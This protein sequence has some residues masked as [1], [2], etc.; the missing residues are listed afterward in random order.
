MIGD[1]RTGVNLPQAGKWFTVE[2]GTIDRRM[3]EE[4]RENRE[5]EIA[6]QLILEA[7]CVADRNPRYKHFQTL[8]PDE[9]LESGL[10]IGAAVPK[11]VRYMP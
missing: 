4:K 6:R 10:K 5:Q 11:V 2:L 1:A 3:F 9:K 7:L 8:F